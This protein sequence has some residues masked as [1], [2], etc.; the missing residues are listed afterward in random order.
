VWPA[1][2][3]GI[4]DAVTINHFV[5][6]VFQK[7]KIVVSR[8][9]FLQFLDELFGVLMA[10]DA[11]CQN[12]SFFFFLLGKKTFQLGE[13]LC[14]VGLPL[15]AVKDQNDA[16]FSAEVGQRERFPFHVFEGEIRRRLT[17][18]NPAEIHWRQVCSVF[19]PSLSKSR[20]IHYREGKGESDQASDD[21]EKFFLFRNNNSQG[22]RPVP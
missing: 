15:A 2:S 10:I 3:V 7:R 6:L 22:I 17:H 12:L 8:K 20:C 16:L 13:L 9:S 18:L 4:E 21:H 11:R 5:V 19:W 1:F 14:A